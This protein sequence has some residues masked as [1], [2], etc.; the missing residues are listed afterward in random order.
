LKIRDRII[1][2][3]T[4]LIAQRG[5]KSFTVD[6]LAAQA[7]ISKRTL[8]RY[9]PSK[10]AVIQAV[11]NRFMEETAQ[12]IDNVLA[13]EK[14]PVNIMHSVIQYLT[15]KAR[16]LNNSQVL[17]DFRQYYP[18]LWQQIDDFRTQKMGSV[19]QM[20]ITDNPNSLVQN[21]DPRI[22]IQVVL[23]SVQSVANPEFILKN[24]LTFE[25]VLRQLSYLLSSLLF[26]KG[27]PD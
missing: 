4:E 11:L 26:T 1:Q 21:M 22:M 16:F 13:K 2:A 17:S 9:F 25:E 15:G 19:L 20:I 10:E 12:H 18:Y 24:N 7:G 14:N 8:Y 5:L 3:C 23:A 6:E 27:A